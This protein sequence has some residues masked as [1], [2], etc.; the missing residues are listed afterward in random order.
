MTIAIKFDDS[1]GRITN[2]YYGNAPDSTWVE[3][4]DSDWSDPNPAPDEIPVFYYDA[5]TGTISIQYE[6][7]DTSEPL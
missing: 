6:T 5:S 3:T 1:T 7:V 2:R 4:I